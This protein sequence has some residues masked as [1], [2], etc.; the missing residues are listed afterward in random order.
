MGE[1][2]PAKAKDLAFRIIDY[3][4]TGVLNTEGLAAVDKDWLVGVSK[5]ID[6]TNGK[7]NGDKR[8]VGRPKIAGLNEKV[9][10]LLD[11]GVT[12]GKQIAA[13][14]HVSSD[15]VYATESWIAHQAKKKANKQVPI[16]IVAPKEEP[17]K[18]VYDF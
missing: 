2:S 13:Q 11:N 6:E 10:E 4:A 14:L 3:G 17:K 1:E 16:P 7:V 18:I 8:S 12:V 9:Q 5:A 15:S